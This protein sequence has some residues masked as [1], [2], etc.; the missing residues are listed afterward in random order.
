MPASGGVEGWREEP[1]ELVVGRRSISGF[2]K[3][4]YTTNKMRPTRNGTVRGGFKAP[5]APSA[6]K[7]AAAALARAGEA[8]GGASFNAGV[9]LFKQLRE[10]GSMED[11]A[12]L[13]QGAAAAGYKFLP[14]DLAEAAV[15]AQRAG[16]VRGE[17]RH[18]EE[19]RRVVAIAEKSVRSFAPREAVFLL[20][21]VAAMEGREGLLGQGQWAAFESQLL[22]K[23]SAV[24]AVMAVALL[25]AVSRLGLVLSVPFYNWLHDT[26]ARHAASLPAAD[27]ES[28]VRA[29]D[30]LKFPISAALTAALRSRTKLLSSE[31][32][33][34]NHQALLALLDAQSS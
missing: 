8:K 7:S 32:G 29:V 33:E 21:A 16:G 13:L 12:G 27:L 20:A 34:E 14:L 17:E 31:L 9:L 24:N 1:G 30:R 4:N 23:K 11:V 28:T 15:A 2:S 6:A 5:Q 10:A 3:P 19:M 25:D 26:L 18:A 22:A